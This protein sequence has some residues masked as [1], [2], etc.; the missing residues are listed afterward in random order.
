[1]LIYRGFSLFSMVEKAEIAQTLD[2]ISIAL[3]DNITVI[4]RGDITSNQI[5]SKLQDAVR[6]IEGVKE[7]VLEL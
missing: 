7:R 5:V 4:Q 2:A 1:M 6:N 3:A